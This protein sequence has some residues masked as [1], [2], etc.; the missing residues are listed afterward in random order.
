MARELILVVVLCCLISIW[1]VRRESNAPVTFDSDSLS[2]KYVEV[3]VNGVGRVY[4]D[5]EVR[6]MLPDMASVPLMGGERIVQDEKGALSLGRMA[7]GKGLLFGFPIDI[8][9]AE[10]DDLLAIPGI[11]PARARSIVQ[12]RERRGGFKSLEDITHVKGIGSKRL[13]KIKPYISLGRS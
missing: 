10:A 11:G 2:V 1:Q 13:E 9:G 3:V 7:G 8:N 5:A 6:A 12:F 4:S